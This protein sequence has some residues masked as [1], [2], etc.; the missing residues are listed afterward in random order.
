MSQC[1]SCA[2]IARDGDRYCS[3]CGTPLA[4][5]QSVGISSSD[6]EF[7]TVGVVD[8]A[9]STVLQACVSELDWAEFQDSYFTEALRVFTDAGGSLEKFIGDAVVGMVSSRKAGDACATAMLEACRTLVGWAA[10]QSLRHGEQEFPVHLR[11]GVATGHALRGAARNALSGSTVTL[12]ARLQATAEP[13]AIVTDETTFLLTRAENSFSAPEL[14]TLKGIPDPVSVRRLS[15]AVAGSTSDLP[16]IPPARQLAT[17]R[18]AIERQV[19]RCPGRVLVAGPMGI[20]KTRLAREV[21]VSLPFPTLFLRWPAGPAITVTAVAQSLIAQVQAEGPPPTPLPDGLTVEELALLLWEALDDHIGLGPCN[22]VFD[23][24]AD[25]ARLFEA[26]ASIAQDAGSHWCLTTTS[27]A[28]PSA[29]ELDGEVLT[30]RRLP[31]AA[32][33]RLYQA[34]RALGHPGAPFTAHDE[35][36]VRSAH[37]NPLFLEQVAHLSHEQRATVG[38]AP[39][40]QAL[41]ASVVANLDPDD[42]MCAAAAA[43]LAPRISTETIQ[44]LLTTLAPDTPLA[45]RADSVVARLQMAGFLKPVGQHAPV[46]SGTTMCQVAF[47]TLTS[48]ERA[49]LLSG[50]LEQDQLER[51]P[52]RAHDPERAL[53]VC[54]LAL[55]A[56]AWDPHY[57]DGYLTTLLPGLIERTVGQLAGRGDFEAAAALSERLLEGFGTARKDTS[58]V[59]HTFYLA[60]AGQVDRSAHLAR[61]ALADPSFSTEAHAHLRVTSLMAG[62]ALGVPGAST[63]AA[64]VPLTEGASPHVRFRQHVLRAFAHLALSQLDAAE[65]ELALASAIPH[66]EEFLGWRGLPTLHTLTALLSGTPFREVESLGLSYLKRV[67]SIPTASAVLES[68]LDMSSAMRGRLTGTPVRRLG[69]RLPAEQLELV[70]A[71]ELAAG[72]YERHAT[73]EALRGQWDASLAF[74][75][76]SARLHHQSGS[77][78]AA[79]RVAV[80]Q[81]LVNAD[82]ATPPPG[83]LY[84]AIRA[85]H[86]HAEQGALEAT[87]RWVDSVCAGDPL[88]A[89]LAAL[90]T[91]LTA[92]AAPGAA[93]QYLTFT[94]R[95]SAGREHA[96]DAVTSLLDAFLRLKESPR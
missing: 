73:A 27:R 59:L 3:A 52:L 14:V 24:C 40:A 54:E 96:R 32:S 93:A 81:A 26:L 61:E 82:P 22:V 55:Q 76:A 72:S 70:G 2:A 67:E 57:A 35:A 86:D 78:D 11:T 58:V 36:L 21:A 39:S 28:E 45:A 30:V 10:Q 95:A 16:Y 9:D 89:P 68:V 46:F 29:D 79:T 56:Y 84:T 60:A 18:A 5:V 91:E 20:G 44:R 41:F 92:L 17:L 1:S 87:L 6:A 74:L 75:A 64:T 51:D 7:V 88:D 48:R 31:H 63:T 38:S 83:A 85:L 66:A 23:A 15:G 8:I 19:L 71:R 69:R 33:V 62:L 80:W 94:L 65:T 50:L 77:R 43:V 49:A 4:S 47:D 25:E 13:G 90:T 53:R 42:R 34:A 12:A 37:G